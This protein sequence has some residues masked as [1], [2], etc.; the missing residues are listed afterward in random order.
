MARYGY[1]LLDQDETD[2]SRQ[3]LQLDGI[4]GFDRI[5]VDRG[6]RAA[7]GLSPVRQ[8]RDMMLNLLRPDDVVFAAAA[9]RL[10]DH[11]RDF[12]QVWALISQRNAHLV[13]LEENID[14]RSNAGR[15]AIKALHAFA[16]LDFNYQSKRKRAGI[17]AAREKGRRI[18]RP[19]VA[20]PPHFRDICRE[21]AEGRLNGHQAAKKAGLKPTSFYKKAAELGFEAP[22]RQ[23]K[24][25]S[26]PH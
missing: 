14:S 2:V 1:M 10:F 20:V 7:P 17:K 16:R 24:N 4:G 11:L 22:G 23:K 9:D 15:Q 19:P 13:M 21:W 18:G 6:S 12:T 5:F 8:Q 26:M 3:A 25:K